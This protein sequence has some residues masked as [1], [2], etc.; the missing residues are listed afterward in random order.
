MTLFKRIIIQF[1]PK[2]FKSGTYHHPEISYKE[3]SNQ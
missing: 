2:T 3:L 1:G